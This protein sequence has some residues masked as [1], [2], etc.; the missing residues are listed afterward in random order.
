MSRFFPALPCP[1]SWSSSSSCPSLSSW[2]LDGLSACLAALASATRDCICAVMLSRL[3]SVSPSLRP[4]VDAALP[5]PSSSRVR[6]RA[7]ATPSLSS[8]SL[9]FLT[10]LS[11]ATRSSRGKSSS[12]ISLSSCSTSCAARILRGTTVFAC[13]SASSSSPKD[14]KD[15]FL[16]RPV[17]AFALF[18]A[19]AAAAAFSCSI[20]C[21]SFLLKRGTMSSK[22]FQSTSTSFI[23]GGSKGLSVSGSTSS[24]FMR[25]RLKIVSPTTLPKMVFLRSN[26]SH[27]SSVMKN[28]LR[29]VWG[30]FWFAHA[31]MP[32]WLNLRRWWNSSLN[33]PP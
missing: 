25:A 20:F 12:R 10:G 32:L 3:P 4:E 17:D 18:C 14:N 30:S 28:W 21:S 22:G 16:A 31:T 2:L 7:A 13:S 6:L 19:A 26:Q 1:S 29:L 24:S 11:R 27:L 9:C 8:P 33:M 5:P 23:V 15:R